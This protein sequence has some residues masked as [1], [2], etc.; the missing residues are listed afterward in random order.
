MLKN[1]L[2]LFFLSIILVLGACAPKR[3]ELPS[4]EGKD[5]REV[6]AGMRGVSEIE[7]TFSITFEKNDTEIRGDAALNIAPSGDMSLRVYSLG[8][9]AMELTS[10]EGNVKSTPQ[11]DRNKKIVL[12]RGLRDCL[13]WWD[14]RDFSMKE[15][16]DDYLLGSFDREL[17]ID[18]QT[19]LPKKQKIYFDDG[20]ALTI[21]Y[22]NPARVNDTWYQSKIRIELLHYSVTLIVKNI[23]FKS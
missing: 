5:L 8:F 17:W 23:S 21:Y 15:E 22:D 10:K 19:F 1:V 9:L 13:F 20:K 12:T 7:T 4:Y 11:L 16:K 14:M 6:M 18:K 3:V 2:R